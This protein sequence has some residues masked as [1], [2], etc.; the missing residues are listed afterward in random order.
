MLLEEIDF[1]A[2]HFPGLARLSL[3]GRSLS[4]VV[5]QRYRMRPQSA[6][7]SFRVDRARRARARLLGLRA[8][9]GDPA[10]RS[11]A[12]LR[13]IG[14]APC[15]RACTAA[16]IAWCSHNVSEETAMLERGYYGRFG[17]A[18]I[19]E[20]LVATFDEL[21]RGVRRARE[22]DPSFWREYVALM[23]SYSCRPTPLTYAENLTRAL[24]RR[25][26][27]HQARGPEPH[28]RAQGQQRDGPGPAR[29]A[30]GQAAA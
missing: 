9:D 6:D 5:E 16:P 26:H 17:G 28:R 4:D 8:G 7:Q 15:S 10:R 25:A 27:L 11:H 22:S 30:H 14:A 21:E 1:D 19:P 23:S 18:Y 20:I 13:A 24:R 29:E 12:A 3:Q 2:E